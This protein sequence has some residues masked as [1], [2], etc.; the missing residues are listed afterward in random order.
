L[1]LGLQARSLGLT[2][3]AL[4]AIGVEQ[5]AS[6]VRENGRHVNPPVNS[7]KNVDSCS[8]QRCTGFTREL[9]FGV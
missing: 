1:S 5:V 8:L 6:L 2:L 3:V 9:L 7:R 4:A